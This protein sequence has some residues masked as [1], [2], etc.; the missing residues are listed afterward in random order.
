[1]NL[2]LSNDKGRNKRRKPATV[3]FYGKIPPQDKD[4]EIAVLA[5]ITLEPS[6]MS[7]VHPIL[8]EDSFYV[9]AHQHIYNACSSLFEKAQPIDTITLVNELKSAGQLE[10]IG[11]PYYLTK[12]QNE[13]VRA[14]NVVQHALIIEEKA[15]AR[16]LIQAAGDAI[17]KL[18][19]GEDDVF[20]LKE[21]LES[22]IF[23][24]TS[25][26]QQQKKTTPDHIAVKFLKQVQRG[27]DA[28][29]MTGVPSGI[30][31]IDEITGGW[32]PQNLIVM[33]ARPR[34]GKS[35]VAAATMRK[36]VSITRADYNPKIHASPSLF[37]SLYM[38]PEMRD[39][40][41]FG[42]IVSTELFDMGYQIQYSR[43]Q[44]G[45]ITEEEL[46]LINEAIN[47][48]VKKGFYIDDT[49][50]LTGSVIKSIVMKHIEK[51][52]IKLVYIDYFQ[53]VQLVKKTTA[54]HAEALSLLMTELKNMAKEL[55][56]PVIL[57]SQVDRGSE[58]S[59]TARRAVLAELKGTGGIEEKADVVII[60][61]YPEINDPNAVD[62]NGTSLRGIMEIDFVKHKM[63]ETKLLR[64]PFNLKYNSFDHSDGLMSGDMDKFL[65]RPIF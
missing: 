47:R 31:E 54:N 64:L 49:A 10:M 14:I 41:L 42:R 45:L 39:T 35:A 26:I 52:G 24:T 7:K 46:N 55:D 13:V 36:T 65:K 27:M 15:I 61:Y 58:K 5:A 18:Y 2:D 4:A 12:M 53:L 37:P 1:M 25:K 48:L 9:E 11:G 20:E 21:K 16:R 23:Q 60:I 63:G 38:T 8:Q 28:S 44:R 43:I 57:L 40:E 29:G 34:H 6:A 50:V 19:T 22:D 51:Y 32:Q 3:D 17:N 62:E 59:G 30:Q 33:A 56:I